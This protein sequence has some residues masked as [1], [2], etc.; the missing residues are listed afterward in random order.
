MVDAVRRVLSVLNG[1]RLSRAEHQVRHGALRVIL[2][3]QLPLMVVVWR[4]GPGFHRSPGGTTEMPGMRHM[5][6]SMVWWMGGAVLLCAIASLTVGSRR[7]GAMLVSLGLLLSAASVVT[8]GGGLTDL[9][10][11]FFVV[12]GLISFYQDWPPLMLAVVL[13]SAHHVVMG[14]LNPAVLYSSPGALLHPL[15]FAMLHVGFIAAAC[16]VQV[17]YWRFAQVAQLE[18]ENARL[19]RDQTMRR[20]AERSEALAQDSRDSIIVMDRQG[21]ILSANAAAERLTGRRPDD[22][23]GT[24]YRTLIHPDDL[25]RLTANT[26]QSREEYRGERRMRQA[27]GNWMWHDVTIRDLTD[28]RAVRGLVANHRDASERRQFQE[29]LVYDASHDALTGLA[30]RAELLRS[31]ERSLSVSPDGS[32]GVAVLYLDLDGFKKINDT[33]GHETGDAL[34]IVVANAL[35]R[36]LLGADSVGR[37]GGDEF[38]VILH[39]ISAARGAIAVAERILAEVSQPVSIN[40]IAVSPRLSI[41]I[42]WRMQGR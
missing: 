40:G 19:D 10:F 1:V 22:L 21:I 42:A 36:S 18:K 8:L 39:Q 3:L 2:W 15:R 37:L 7:G 14:V 31:L 41:G 26:D 16:V 30:N 33:Y 13:I 38:A 12:V 25:S 29:T 35:R 6:S 5:D 32:S 23:V 17:V 9:H 24:Q 27:D 4:L 28:H 34:L 20:I 11:G